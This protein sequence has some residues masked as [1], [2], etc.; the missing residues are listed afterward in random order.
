[1][2]GPGGGARRDAA[3]ADRDQAEIDAELVHDPQMP[4]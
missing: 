1:M 2:A 4:A 3:A